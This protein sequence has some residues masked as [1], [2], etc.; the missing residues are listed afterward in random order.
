MQLARTLRKM[1]A[2]AASGSIILNI[3]SCSVTTNRTETRSG[4][5]LRSEDGVYIIDPK[6]SLKSTINEIS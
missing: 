4:L 2:L 5:K 3:Q 1:F 6:T